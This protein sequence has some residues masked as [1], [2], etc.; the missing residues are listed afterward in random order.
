[1]DEKGGRKKRKK[2][3]KERK[4]IEIDRK[5]GRKEQEDEG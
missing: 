3:E 1:M 2:I 4:K 5:E